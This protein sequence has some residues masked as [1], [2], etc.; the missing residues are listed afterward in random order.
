MLWTEFGMPSATLEHGARKFGDRVECS[1][2]DLTVAVEL[3]ANQILQQLNYDLK[4][5]VATIK[6]TGN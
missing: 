2:D 1:S 4:E 3:Y 6:G 5:K